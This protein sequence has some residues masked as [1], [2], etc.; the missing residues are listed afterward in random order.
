[1]P[2]RLAQATSPY[3]LQHANNPVDWYEW[4]SEA[5][6]RARSEDKPILLSIGYAACHWCHV[7]ERESFEDA[8]TAAAMNDRFVCIKVDREER[9]DLDQIYMAAVQAMT[10]HGGWPMT[11]FLTPEG[12]PFWG[13]TYFPPEPRHGMP[14]FGQ[15]LAA[16]HDAWTT[17]RAE[18][19]QQGARLTEH[20]GAQ[21]RLRD[22]GA[23][24]GED[25]VTDAAR[26]MIEALDDEWGGFGQ[27]PKFPQPMSLEFLLRAHLRGTPDALSAVTLSLT[28]MARGGIF[29]QVGGGFHRYAVD[30]IWLVPHFEKMLYDNAQL[31]RLYARAWQVVGDPL[32]AETALRTAEYLMREMRHPDGGFFSSQDAD[33]EGVEGTF[34]VWDYDELIALAGEDMPL[35]IAA[36]AASGDGNWEGSNIL[37][38]PDPLDEVA[39][40]TGSSVD[41][42]RAAVARVRDRLF[43]VRAAR[44]P[45]ATDDKVLAA[46][47]G[48]AIAG[49]AETG[50]I[51]GRADLIEA[52]ARAADFVLANLRRD[53][54]RLLRAWRDGRTSGLGFL[55]DHA[56]MADACLTLYETTFEPRWW[57]TARDLEAQMR[58]LFADPDGGG[59]F[60][61]GS[62]AE[63][64]LLRPKELV[65][66]A[67]PSGNATA[68]DVLLRVAALSG[69]A[70]PERV[71]T[72]FLRLVTPLMAGS[73]LGFGTALTAVDRSVFPRR[74]IAV[75]GEPGSADTE[76]LIQVARARFIPDAVV[77]VGPEGSIEPALLRDRP[78]RDGKATAYVCE[79]FACKEP[80]TT[81]AE[82]AAQ[83]EP[84]RTDAAVS[85][86][87]ADTDVPL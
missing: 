35:A 71:A 62:D 31:V 55:D 72:G 59:F 48:L 66:N 23:L 67:V 16:I 74:E 46:W 26:A 49:L 53:D 52:A 50:R 8:A 40:D 85:S 76:A 6:E 69:E 60:D 45:P 65:D 86:G 51:F 17:K 41:E 36:F 68:S 61:T 33:S 63:R 29:D 12:R 11:V 39:T 37:W 18:I 4:G 30:R 13:G 75:V 58:A 28:K 84:A 5:L 78:T 27:A 77:A 80:V 82:L 22:T 73:P 9:P 14:A 56:M 34:Y 7:M 57:D 42:V 19:T 47:N 81:P 87:R 3:L 43:D 54:G 83:L 20:I 70:E 1:M 64:I 79:H 2:N 10:G 21:A 38:H 24:L 15:V 25:V 44:V 32:Y